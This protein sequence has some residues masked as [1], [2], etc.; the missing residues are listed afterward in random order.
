MMVRLGLALSIWLLATS[1]SLAAFA[2]N[3]LSCNIFTP[4]AHGMLAKCVG[5]SNS[6]GDIAIELFGQTPNAVSSVKLSGEKDGFRQELSVTAEPVVDVETVGILFMDFNFDGL[7]DFALMEFL[8]AGPNV[9]YLYYLFD[10]DTRRFVPN[11][12]L[13]A[14]TSPVFEA[15]AKQIVSHW[16]ENAAVSGTDI[17]RWNNGKP[18][19]T[20]RSEDRYSASGC[21]R[22]NY[23]MQS[24]KLVVTSKGKCP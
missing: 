4:S 21:T 12:D 23:S 3:N 2:A 22:T 19:L 8:P 7:E 24:G 13:A 18:A 16:R 1:T 17:Y 5:P 20:N 9:P 15:D 6:V 11:A 10:P 14:I